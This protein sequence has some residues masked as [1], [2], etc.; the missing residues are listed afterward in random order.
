MLLVLFF[1][2]FVVPMAAMYGFQSIA[3]SDQP[4]AL[5]HDVAPLTA[6]NSGL[7]APIRPLVVE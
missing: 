4:Q 5:R 7:I 3:A 6:L 2:M 1:S